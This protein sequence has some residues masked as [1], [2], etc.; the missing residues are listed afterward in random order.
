MLQDLKPS[1]AL[2]ISRNLRAI[3]KGSKIPASTQPGRGAGSQ[4]ARKQEGGQ[5]PSKHARGTRKLTP[6][7][8]RCQHCCER[9]E[10]K[11]LFESNKH[12]D[13]QLCRALN[14]IGFQHLLDM[15]E[16]RQQLNTTKQGVWNNTL[17]CS[18]P[19]PT[20]GNIMQTMRSNHE[21]FVLC[22][23]II[24]N[25]LSPLSLTT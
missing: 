2:E 1:Q 19:T 15:H 13:K 6:P 16:I 5:D 8:R 24:C 22:N 21:A 9:E 10:R 25:R 11:P 14:T 4:Q 7:S 23:R 3:Q 18:A 17:I 12:I 20:T